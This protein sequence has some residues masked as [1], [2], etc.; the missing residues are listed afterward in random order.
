MSDGVTVKWREEE[1]ND[2]KVKVELKEKHL[3]QL[4]LTSPAAGVFS[5]KFSENADETIRPKSQ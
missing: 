1:W 3:D 4:T 5:I 2:D